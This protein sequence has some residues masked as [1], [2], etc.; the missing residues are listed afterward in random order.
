MMLQSP[1]HN[2]LLHYRHPYHESEG[3]GLGT[4][5]GWMR[6][7]TLISRGVSLISYGGHFG[8][9]LAVHILEQNRQIQAAQVSAAAGAVVSGVGTQGVT[10]SVWRG[11]V[12]RA[13]RRVWRSVC[14]VWPSRMGWSTR[15]CR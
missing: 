4:R 8:P 3:C 12:S 10:L 15:P 11:V 6:R 13:R 2:R 5:H 1:P 14:P 7:L 9:N